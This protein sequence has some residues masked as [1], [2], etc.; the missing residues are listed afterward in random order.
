MKKLKFILILLLSISIWSCEDDDADIDI[1]PSE[2]VEGVAVLNT[3]NVIDF[4][5]TETTDVV[6][7]NENEI[8]TTFTWSKVTGNYNGSILYFLEMD[9]KGNNFKNGVYAPLGSQ[10]TTELSKEISNSDLNL[11][12][13]AINTQLVTLGSALKVDF[14]TATEFDIRVVSVADISKDKSF[15]EPIT[16]NINAYEKIVV[17]EPQLFIAG[18][19]Q[20]YYGK[21][22]WNPEQGLEMRYIGD[23]TT[24]V[25]EAYLKATEGDIFK[26]I[27]NQAVWDNVVG[28]YGVIDGAQDGNLINSSDSGNIEIPEEGQY[29]IKVDIDNLTYKLIKMQWGVIGNATPNGWDGETPMT[30]DFNTNT[31]EIT[32]S[33]TDGEVKFRSKSL[34]NAVFGAG[35]EWIWKFNV[36]TNLNAW[37]E[38]EGNFVVSAGSASLTLKIGFKGDAVVTGI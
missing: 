19:V 37:D 6:V 9:I 33:L 38:G 2:T 31:W 4:E 13:N 18:S 15:S 24:K 17:I 32:L 25:F 27:S 23:G 11:A 35:E 3:P 10:G 36:G 5:I 7:G 12:V 34:S 29:Y 8:A 30:Y 26:F 22:N 16:I 14:S 20:S 28:N 1:F 21:S